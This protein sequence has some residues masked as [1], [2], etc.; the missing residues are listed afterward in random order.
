MLGHSWPKNEP[1][2]NEN[3]GVGGI[4]NLN[5]D[6]GGSEPAL[7]IDGNDGEDHGE[8]SKARSPERVVE[9][10][11]SDRVVLLGHVAQHEDHVHDDQEKEENC[12]ECSATNQVVLVQSFEV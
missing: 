10:C 1:E 5:G 9:E 12:I 2:D 7:F 11:D 3:G 6:V 4:G 8:E